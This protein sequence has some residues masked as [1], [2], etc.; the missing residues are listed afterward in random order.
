MTKLASSISG[1]TTTEREVSEPGTR[2]TGWRAMPCYALFIPESHHVPWPLWGR[3]CHRANMP[4][5]HV[6]WI[7]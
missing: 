2:V 1:A 7:W 5:W 6:P 4:H 3:L